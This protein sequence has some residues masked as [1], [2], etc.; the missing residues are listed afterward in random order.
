MLLRNDVG[1]YPSDDTASHLRLLN[2]HQRFEPTAIT[3]LR[4]YVR[5]VLN[6]TD[7]VCIQEY[8]GHKLCNSQ[9][10]RASLFLPSW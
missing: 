1:N 9:L 2:L 10:S 8:F 7:S 5:V 4:P 3:N 6:N